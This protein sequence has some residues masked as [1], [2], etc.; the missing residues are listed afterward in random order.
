MELQTKRLFIA[1]HA[2]LQRIALVRFVSVWFAA[3]VFGR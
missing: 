2:P 3:L 1:A